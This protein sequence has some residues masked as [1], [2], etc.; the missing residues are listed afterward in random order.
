MHKKW[1]NLTTSPKRIWEKEFTNHSK[2]VDTKKIPTKII[3][4]TR[5]VRQSTE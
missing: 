4:E 2:E 1:Q 5:T 3:L